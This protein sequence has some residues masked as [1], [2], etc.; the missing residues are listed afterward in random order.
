MLFTISKTLS[1]R[2]ISLLS[3]FLTLYLLTPLILLREFI[4]VYTLNCAA[5][6]TG[7]TPHKHT[8]TWASLWHSL[9]YVWCFCSV[10][11][12][13]ALLH[14]PFWSLICTPNFEINWWPIPASSTGSNPIEWVWRELK[15]QS[16]AYI[17]SVKETAGEGNMHLLESKYFE[18]ETFVGHQ[19]SQTWSTSCPVAN[20]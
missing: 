20:L 13:S 6:L 9:H 17:A 10:L 8:I 15:M 19:H 18:F 14:S 7:S 2:S 12:S 11:F 1:K 16:V 3:I 4:C 5:A